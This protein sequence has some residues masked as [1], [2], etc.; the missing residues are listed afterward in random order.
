MSLIARSPKQIGSI[1]QNLR[2]RRGLTQGQ[3]AQLAGARQEMVSIIER[4]HPGAKLSLIFDLLAAL[5]LE[6]S[7]QPRSKAAATE[8]ADIF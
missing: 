7:L 6:L 4:G 2:Q 1:I 8:V 3:L 5:D